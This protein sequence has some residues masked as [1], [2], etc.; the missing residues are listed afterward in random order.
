MAALFAAPMVLPNISAGAFPK[1]RFEA[2]KKAGAA[3][4]S[5]FC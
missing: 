3:R 1:N 2:F 5:L 4:K